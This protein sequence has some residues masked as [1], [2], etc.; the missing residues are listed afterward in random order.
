M[1]GDFN[2]RSP[3]DETWNK[4][5]NLDDTRYKVQNYI[6][7]NTDYCDVIRN[8]YGN[9]WAPS[10]IDYMYVSPDMMKRVVRAY[11]PYE[12]DDMTKR[13]LVVNTDFYQYS[14]HYGIIV[15]FDMSK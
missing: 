11:M 13:V 9:K 5:G 10:R 3:L 1:C 4:F 7:K 12:E 15:E 6:L 2:S 8:I 14:D